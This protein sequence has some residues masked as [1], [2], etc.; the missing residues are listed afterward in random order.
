MAITLDGDGQWQ[1]PGAAPVPHGE[2]AALI[3][4]GSALS[5][6]RVHGLFRWTRRVAVARCRYWAGYV[7]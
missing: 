1:P 6:S 3:G 4:P 7:S 2:P 5:Q